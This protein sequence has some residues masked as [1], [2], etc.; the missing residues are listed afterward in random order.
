MQEILV[1]HPED[2]S[3]C[4][5]IVPLKLAAIHHKNIIAGHTHRLSLTWD[6]SAKY[7]VVECGHMRDEARTMY[8]CMKMASN[9]KWNLGHVIVYRGNPY[10]INEDNYDFFYNNVKLD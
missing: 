8:K 5:S 6:P 4:P 7:Y 3:R 9:P 1:V 2:Y 10:L